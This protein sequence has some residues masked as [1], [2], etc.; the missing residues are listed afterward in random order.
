MV[1]PATL[2]LMHDDPGHGGA[3]GKGVGHHLDH[4]IDCPAEVVGP[5]DGDV[6]RIADDV[7]GAVG[8]LHR[9]DGMAVVLAEVAVGLHR[10]DVLVEADRA[11]LRLHRSEEHTSELQSLMRISYAVF[12]LKK[13]KTINNKI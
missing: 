7:D 8:R 11:L 2:K 10:H 1:G 4:R 9:D 12:C 5:R 3:G 13:K 6:A